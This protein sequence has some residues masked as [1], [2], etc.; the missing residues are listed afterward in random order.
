[1]T[2]MMGRPMQVKSDSFQERL[3]MKQNRKM[4]LQKYHINKLSFSLKDSLM[5]L[6][7]VVIR[8]T[9]SPEV[10]ERGPQLQVK[11]VYGKVS[12]HSYG[13]HVSCNVF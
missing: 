7:S 8:D 13:L 11:G 4:T 3:I 6:V 5:V 10:K 9:I 1:M 12:F 2:Q